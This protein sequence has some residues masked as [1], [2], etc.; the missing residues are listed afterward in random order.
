MFLKN[1][2]DSNRPFDANFVAKYRNVSD[3]FCIGIIHS[4]SSETKKNHFKEMSQNDSW[5]LDQLKAENYDVGISEA[6]DP[7]IF[8]IFEKVNI[9]TKLISSALNLLEGVAEIYGI[10]MPRSYVPSNNF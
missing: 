3:Q 6:I 1:P 10:P 5:L 2:F 8:G 9:R 4:H 7:C